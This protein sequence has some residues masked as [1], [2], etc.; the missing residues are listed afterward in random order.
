[1][2]SY[3]EWP[4]IERDRRIT[5]RHLGPGFWHFTV[6]FGFIEIPNVPNALHTAKAQCP[7]DLDD[8]VYFSELDHV[9]RR[10]TRPRM[11]AW[12]R[13]LFSFLYRNAVH[14]GDRFGLPPQ[15]FVQ[16]GRQR[17]I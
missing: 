9:T 8:A 2:A 1:L 11:A 4:R 12:R 3:C 13:I 17:E 15:N 5:F 14:Q 16:I 7:V 10:K 6:T